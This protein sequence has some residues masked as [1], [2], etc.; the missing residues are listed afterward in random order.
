[1]HRLLVF[2]VIAA[3]FIKAHRAIVSAV[4]E[5]IMIRHA[6]RIIVRR[7]FQPHATTVIAFR[8]Q[9]GARHGLIIDSQLL[10]ANMQGIL[11]LHVIQALEISEPLPV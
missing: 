5:M 8:I 4:T 10:P 9:A 11:V 2:P 3:V 7:V 6:V 1:M